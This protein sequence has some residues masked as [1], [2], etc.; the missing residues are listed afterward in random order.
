MEAVL[1]IESWT[2]VT[3]LRIFSGS[4]DVFLIVTGI[5]R[6]LLSLDPY[7]REHRER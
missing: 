5:D 6:V 4:T 7:L 2:A 1:H 3:N